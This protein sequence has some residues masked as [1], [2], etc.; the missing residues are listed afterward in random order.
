LIKIF[1]QYD[2]GL[3]RV[4]MSILHAEPAKAENFNRLKIDGIAE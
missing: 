1:N 3:K 4:K 2:C